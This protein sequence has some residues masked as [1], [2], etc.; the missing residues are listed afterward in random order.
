VTI[1]Q[2]DKG[3]CLLLTGRGAKAGTVLVDGGMRQSYSEHVAPALSR[4]KKLDLVYVSHIDQDHIAGVL[5]MMDDLVAW[6]VHDFQVHNGN[7]NHR[8]PSARRPPPVGAIWHNAF[9]EQVGKNAGPIQ[10]LL[11]ATAV[12]LSGAADT[13][14]AEIAHAHQELATSTR[15]AIQLSRRIG[16]NQLKVPL[17][18][19]FGGK[20]MF[21]R[22]GAPV[23]RLGRMS[24]SVLGPF[25]ADLANLRKEW[26][27]WLEANEK[28]LRDI[29]RQ[30]RAD[31]ERL[32]TSEVDRI[33]R[34]LLAQAEAL[35]N[36]DRVTVPNLASLMVLIEEDGKTVLLGGD[37]HGNDILRG[38]AHHGRLDG[39]GGIHLDVLKVQHHGSEHN[40]DAAF[41]KAVTADHYIF[42]G[43]GAH[44]NPD[45]RV[46]ELIVNSRIGSAA[47]RS[48]N[49]QAANRFTLWFN[50][51][52]RVPGKVENQ[53]Q[54]RRIEALLRRLAKR[55]RGQM[56]YRMQTRSARALSI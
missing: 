3:D 18:P 27:E 42:C 22:P 15:E 56:A 30:A 31:E 5:Q 13:T 44:A 21:V 54:M 52:S 29:E 39:T 14:I 4:L 8:P 11:A 12:V 55:S 40:I 28:A 35:G 36:R 9:H 38:L 23:I 24:I 1:F 49:R 45:E 33:V 26:N 19:E 51:S 50:S 32:A 34:P 48:R 53:S 6:R 46:V 2:S 16:A 25:E 7:A 20:L 10:D 41:C 17:N 43:N 37:G 47:Q